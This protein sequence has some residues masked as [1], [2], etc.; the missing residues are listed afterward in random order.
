VERDL[1]CPG[2]CRPER[3]PEFMSIE[4]EITQI[5]R[6]GYLHHKALHESHRAI[7]IDKKPLIVESLSGPE[8]IGL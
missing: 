1:I 5:E 2:D 6:I 4:W 7:G 3:D 8:I